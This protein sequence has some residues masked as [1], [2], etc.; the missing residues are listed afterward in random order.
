MFERFPKLR[1]GIMEFG[2]TW[3]GQCCERMD[4]WADFKVRVLGRKFEAFTARGE[5]VGVLLPN[6]NAVALTFFALQ[7]IG[8][9]PAMLNYTGGANNMSAP[10]IHTAM[11]PNMKRRRPNSK[12]ARPTQS[13][14]K[15]P[16]K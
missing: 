8:R 1:F 9:V 7:S 11:T 14:I 3:I 15:L 10:Q 12:M 13:T 2:T 5:H 6:A 4:T 16:L